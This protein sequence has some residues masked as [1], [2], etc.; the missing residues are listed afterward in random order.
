MQV[1][2]DDDVLHV[3]HVIELTDNVVTKFASSIGTQ[4]KRYAKYANVMNERAGSADGRFVCARIRAHPVREIVDDANDVLI[5]VS[6]WKWQLQNINGQIG[7]WRARD[8]ASRHGGACRT[9]AHLLAAD[10][11]L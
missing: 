4:A 6:I 1:R 3:H 2:L 8:Y 11:A 10:T 9:F 7:K 5:V